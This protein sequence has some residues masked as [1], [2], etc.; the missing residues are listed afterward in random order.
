MDPWLQLMGS[1][2]HHTMRNKKYEKIDYRWWI[3]SWDTIHLPNLREH[4]SFEIEVSTCR[5]EQCLVCPLIHRRPES[6]LNFLPPWSFG[7]LC[8][9]S[10]SDNFFSL[11]RIRETA[12]LRQ[13]AIWI[14]W[15]LIVALWAAQLITWSILWVIQ[16]KKW[17][18]VVVNVCYFFF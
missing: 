16:G 14:R 5:V 10:R 7:F 12:V 15:S 18:K 17:F 8:W 11:L 1:P 4:S 9:I 3:L 13:D 2:T 6:I